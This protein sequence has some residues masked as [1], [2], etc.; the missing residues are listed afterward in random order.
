M[1]ALLIIDVQND[2]LPGGALAVPKG[3]EIIPLINKLQ[4]QFS[5]VVA[6]KDWH[7]PKHISFAS[8]HGKQVGDMIEV[9]GRNQELWPDHCIQGTT[10]AEFPKDLKKEK[11]EK[12]VFKG[13]NPQIDSYSTFF[14]NAR[15][16]ST[17]LGEYLQSIGVDEIYIAGLATDYCVK[18]SVLDAKVFG[19]KIHVVTDACR[20]ID[21][22]PGDIQRALED[23]QA[24]GADFVTSSILLAQA[25]QN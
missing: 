10:G 15:L 2:F 21:L 25:F 8:S 11:I 23:M 1:K 19:F 5:C 4:N 24:A 3:D 18:F 14:D 6:T 12:V 16:R 20:G 22:N 9:E 13:V 7:P 17:G